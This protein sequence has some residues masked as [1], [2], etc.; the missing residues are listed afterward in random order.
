MP[1]PMTNIE[2]LELDYVPAHLIVL[3]GGY[4]GIE[5]AQAYRRFGSRV[6]IVQHG[7]QIAAREDEDVVDELRRLLSDEGIDV[8][9]SADTG[10]GARP[11]RQ[12]GDR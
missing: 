11:L 3:G 12:R 4:V 7:T 6:T 5:L 9:E 1:Q 8:I 2:L 10:R